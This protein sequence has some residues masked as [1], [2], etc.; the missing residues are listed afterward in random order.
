MFVIVCAFC[1]VPPPGGRALHWALA[2]GVPQPLPRRHHRPSPTS[3]VPTFCLVPLFL[4]R[5]IDTPRINTLSGM[6]RKK[7]QAAVDAL[8]AALKG[9]GKPDAAAL[10]AIDALCPGESSGEEESGDEAFAARHAKLEAEERARYESVPGGSQSLVGQPSFP[11]G[12]RWCGA[13]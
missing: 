11:R 1:L 8:A 12:N 7:R 4:Q 9:G 2:A 5:E 6:E 13:L 10:A 3:H